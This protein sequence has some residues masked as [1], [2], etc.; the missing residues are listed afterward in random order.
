MSTIK[1]LGEE[2][3]GVEVEGV[4][5][6]KKGSKKRGFLPVLLWLQRGDLQFSQIC[7]LQKN[8]VDYFPGDCTLE[9]FEEMSAGLTDKTKGAFLAALKKGGACVA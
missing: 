7:E 6:Q 5:F 9:E 8:G 2:I 3:D 4:F 1:F